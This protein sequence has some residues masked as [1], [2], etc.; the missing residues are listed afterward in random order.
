M[1]YKLLHNGE[2]ILYSI[3]QL[4]AQDEVFL[5]ISERAYAN[6]M[7]YY[8]ISNYGRLYNYYTQRFIT[9]AID[10][11]GYLY[12]NL[13]GRDEKGHACRIHRMLMTTFNPCPYCE[14]LLIN[15]KDG[16]KLNNS[17]SNLEW[18]DYSYNSLEAYRIGLNRN[19]KGEERSN[20][21][22]TNNQAELICQAMTNPCRKLT[23]IALEFNVPV[24]ILYNINTGRAWKHIADKYT[25][26][27][28]REK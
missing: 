7:P 4:I 5:S 11:K 13:R 16:N 3:P 26:P 19:L 24:Q 28:R 6:L 12:A 17:L 23:D 21:T 8:V 1:A 9:P 14:E 20:A 10:S 2:K 22:L 15:H 27:K 18:C 25:F